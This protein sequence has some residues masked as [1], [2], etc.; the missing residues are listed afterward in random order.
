MNY[1]PK[2][3]HEHLA[4]CYSR[5][6]TSRHI[7]NSAL[8]QGGVSIWRYVW[9]WR[10]SV[11]P[12]DRGMGVLQHAAGSFLSKKSKSCSRLHSVGRLAF[13]KRKSSLFKPPFGKLRGNVRTWSIVRWKARVRLPI[14]HK[15]TFPLAFTVETLQE[16]I[17][18]C[19][20]FLKG[21]GWVTSIAH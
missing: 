10:I 4:N 19:E 14:R 12:F 17:C 21:E 13:Q 8:R 9:G 3:I 7:Y 18:R 16:K 11:S 20:Q 2:Y 15:W 6:T 1:K 5:W